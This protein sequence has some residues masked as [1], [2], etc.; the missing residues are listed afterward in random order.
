MGNK[1][2]IVQPYPGFKDHDGYPDDLA[3]H[4][5]LLGAGYKWTRHPNSFED[6]GD[7]ESGPHLAG[8]P[9]YDEYASPDDNE[10]VY[11]N[12]READRVFEQ[13]GM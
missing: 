3:A 8:G 12:W 1:N 9:A 7:A 2:L 11:V 5:F 10:H 4:V 6:D 13:E